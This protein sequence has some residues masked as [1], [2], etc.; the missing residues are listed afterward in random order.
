MCTL[1]QRIHRNGKRVDVINRKRLHEDRTFCLNAEGFKKTI[2]LH[3]VCNDVPVREHGAFGHP[4]GAPCV[5]QHRKVGQSDINRCVC[6]A[7]T[8]FK[9]IVKLNDIG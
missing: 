9:H 2:Q 3:D 5:L 4:C 8:F 7:C 6:L 1:A